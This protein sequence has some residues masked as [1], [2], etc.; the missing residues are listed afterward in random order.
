MS[1]A[2]SSRNSFFPDN[3]IGSLHF[4]LRK[5]IVCSPVSMIAPRLRQTL[6]EI[7][8]GVRVS[9]IAILI[10]YWSKGTSMAVLHCTTLLLPKRNDMF[11]GC[12]TTACCTVHGRLCRNSATWYRPITVWDAPR[13]T[14]PK[15]W[16]VANKMDS[17]EVDL[18][19]LWSGLTLGVFVNFTVILGSVDTESGLGLSGTTDLS[20]VMALSFGEGLVVTS[21]S[22]FLEALGSFALWNFA[23]KRLRKSPHRR[24][25]GIS[26]WGWLLNPTLTSDMD[27]V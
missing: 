19:R 20:P 6:L 22:S 11:T 26:C 2:K 25:W 15:V 17:G 16:F 9:T 3:D 12:S 23:V 18:I 8:N 21:A 13:S 5:K 27:L 7:R 1:S 4:S 14:I 24:V 10:Q